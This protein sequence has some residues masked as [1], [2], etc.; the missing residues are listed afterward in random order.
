MENILIEFINTLDASLKK[1]EKQVGDG[2]GTSR[3]TINQLNYIQA[4]HELGEPTLSEL[5]GKLN[6][7]KASVTTGINK[8]VRMGYVIKTQSTDD[9]RV[10]HVN[11]T[12]RGCQLI[13][14]K[15]QALQEYDAFIHAALS[16]EEIRQ[17][18][19]ILVKLVRHFARSGDSQV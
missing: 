16:E 11:L 8:L 10:I 18:Q 7:T 13:Q 6:F 2:S 15:F 3:L 17:F 14:A 9:R 19:A 5:A 4:I 1:L 12:E